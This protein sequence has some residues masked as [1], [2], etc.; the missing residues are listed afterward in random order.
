M[1]V[2]IVRP[3]LGTVE[4]QRLTSGEAVSVAIYGQGE[5]VKSLSFPELTVFVNA[6]FRA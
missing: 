6:I 4:V 5:T 3:A 2:W 1:E